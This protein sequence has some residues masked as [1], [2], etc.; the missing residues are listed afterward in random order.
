[1]KLSV[2][3]IVISTT[4]LLS[5]AC[6]NRSV[7]SGETKAA[8]YSDKNQNPAYSVLADRL[9][10]PWSI[11]FD[12]DTI[13]VSERE[14]NIVKIK[15]GTAMR[16]RVSLNKRLKVEGEGGFLGLELA[17]D[18]AASK[19]AFAYHTYEEAGKVFNRLVVI[20]ETPQG[21]KEIK[22][23]LERIPGGYIHNGGRL[24]VGPDKRLYATT[25]DS[26][27][28]Q[29][30][31]DL[32]S[33]AGK[34]LRMSLD[35]KVPSDNPFPGSY[36][37]SYGHRNSQGIAWDGQGRM[38]SSEHGPSGSPGGHDEIN[39]IKP[40]LNYGWPDIIGDEQ[41]AGMI[42]PL[43]HTGETAIAP[44]GIAI[45]SDNHIWIAALRGQK[46]Y[47]YDPAA[48]T[49]PAILENKG[50]LRDVKIHNRNIYVITNNTDGR[51][52]PSPDDDLLIVLK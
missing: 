33:N 31:Q 6:S 47:K 41:K 19:Q 46:L 16:Q 8:I 15:D 24:A 5:A 20:Q 35:G 50:R 32:K 22:S 10:T 9:H 40:G 26:G 18:F 45:D 29:L 25:G 51:G 14:G 43:Y 30:A 34:I 17:P 44:S 7:Y 38:Y 52:K 1:M 4:L 11:Q 2:F 13:Y 48:K 27:Q 49:M 3:L 12:G 42:N 21:W 39:L 28:G 36:V 37:Y 23:Y